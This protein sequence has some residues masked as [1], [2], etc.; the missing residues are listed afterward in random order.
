VFSSNGSAVAWESGVAPDES[1]IYYWLP[2]SDPVR[3]AEVKSQGLISLDG[4]TLY[5][6][7][8]PLAP[9]ASAH[10]VSR[11][12]LPSQSAAST[13]TIT[14]R[15]SGMNAIRNGVV[16]YF[17][18]AGDESGAW[19]LRPLDSSA[20]AARATKLAPDINGP[21]LI[22]WIDDRHLVSY[23]NSGIA[24]FDT[25]SGSSETIAAGGDVSLTVPRGDDGYLDM[26]WNPTSAADADAAI[27]GW[28]HY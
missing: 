17:P 9:G 20:P 6:T 8:S 23:A 5:A 2:G 1:D 10:V 12:P 28:R 14:Y 4:D 26:G 15:G 7:Q 11:I 25:A 24:V 3:V 27:V 13:Q 16:A 19:T 18:G 21:Y 22:E